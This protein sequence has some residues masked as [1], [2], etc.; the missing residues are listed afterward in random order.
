MSIRPQANGRA[1]NLNWIRT[2]EASA[3][4][5]SFTRAAEELSLTQ[6]GVSQHIRMLEEQLGERLFTRLPRAVRLTEAGEAYLKVVRESLD[7]LRLGTSDIFGPADEGEIRLRV[8]PAFFTY[9]LAPRLGRFLNTYPDIG[10]HLTPTSQAIDTD[11]DE[12]DLEISQ[13][14]DRVSGLDAIALLGDPVFPVCRPDVAADLHQPEDI[15]RQRLLH[16]QGNLDA[17][18]EWFAVARLF[19]RSKSP[20]LLVDCSSAA[21][22]CAEEGLGIALGSASL[23]T[24]QLES[25]RLIRPFPSPLETI[26]IFYL[27]T[28]STHRLRR[29]ARLFR[30]WLL[31][32]GPD[33]HEPVE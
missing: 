27:L 20:S 8:D 30:D 9:W 3:R 17:W 5:L 19:S 24:R 22:T 11:W 18:P 12:F 32:E 21:I 4:L 25:G 15:L 33:S 26:G 6:A 10:L 7:R 14:S 2:F 29:Q 13:D 23:I 1:L 28:P 16:V 31:A